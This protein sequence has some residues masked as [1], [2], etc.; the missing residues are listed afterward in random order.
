HD[1]LPISRRPPAQVFVVTGMLHD[2]VSHV[3]FRGPFP[4]ASVEKII[5]HAVGR[6]HQVVDCRADALAIPCLDGGGEIHGKRADQGKV[7]KRGISRKRYGV[8]AGPEYGVLNGGMKSLMCRNRSPV[9]LM[10]G[11]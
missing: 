10:P 8:E 1:A 3:V 2:R 7:R 5:T 6:L 9:G 11:G 4:I